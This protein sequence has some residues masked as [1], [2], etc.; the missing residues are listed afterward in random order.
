LAIRNPKSFLLKNTK[1]FKLKLFEWLRSHEVFCILNSNHY[2]DTYPS[3]DFIVAAGVQSELISDHHSAFEKLS[4]FN[5]HKKTRIFGY[6][7]YDLKNDIEKL[8]SENIDRLKFPDL[9]FFEPKIILHIKQDQLIIHSVDTDEKEILHSIEQCSIHADQSF[10][11][12]ETKSRITKE[13][14]LEKI[15][16]LKEHIIEGDIYEINFCQEFFAENCE[17]DPYHIY[18]ELNT[19]SPM[20]FSSFFRIKDKWI[21]CASPERFIK[22]ENDLLISQPIK[23]TARRSENKEE[24]EQIK[25]ALKNDPKEQAE[26]VMIVDLVRNDLTKSSVTGSIRVEELF[27]IYSFAHLHQMI[28]TITSKIKPGYSI[29]DVLNN[30]FPMGS[31]TG[32]PKI[33]AMKLSEQYEES[34]RG[35][36]SGA[37]GY[38]DESNDFDFNVVI[39]TILYNSTEK[40]LSFHVGGA[41]TY[42]SI[43]EKEYEECL[44][45]AKAIMDVLANVKM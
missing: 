42:D 30:T 10:Y 35:V 3:F 21:C 44:L 15:N 32:A 8:S 6:L 29:I 16:L 31:M 25:Q 11:K 19:A 9:Y 20:P 2:Q 14:Y 39:R 37:I 12:P 24:D 7:G 40:Y 41:I 23:G 33:M 28:S 27:G 5:Q 34:K 13:K 22:K 43:P 17:V 1:E 38:I 18:R 26:N 36:Y 45:K 4:H